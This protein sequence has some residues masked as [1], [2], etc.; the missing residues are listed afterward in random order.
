MNAKVSRIARLFMILG[1]VVFV[2]LL[3]G[4]LIGVVFEPIDPFPRAQRS[5]R[6]ANNSSVVISERKT[7]WFTRETELSVH[8]ID[9]NGMLCA[10][11]DTARFQG[12]MTLK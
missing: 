10:A 1:A 3:I 11:A 7:G 9:P 5:V 6:C 12:G 2:I 8:Y 4:F